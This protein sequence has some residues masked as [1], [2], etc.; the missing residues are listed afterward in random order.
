MSES[1]YIRDGIIILPPDI[2]MKP[3]LDIAPKNSE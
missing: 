1:I 3:I 2:A